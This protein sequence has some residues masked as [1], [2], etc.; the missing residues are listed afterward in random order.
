LNAFDDMRAAL[1]IARDV[2]RAADQNAN[3]MA[4]MLRHRLR[5]V[6]N[7]DTLI[8]LKRELAGF[9]MTTRKWRAPR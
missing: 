1:N 3:Q 8:A 4:H 6:D 7:S 5:H 2:Q 9:N